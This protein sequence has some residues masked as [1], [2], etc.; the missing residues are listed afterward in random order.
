MLVL[1]RMAKFPGLIQEHPLRL[2]TL[3]EVIGFMYPKI[4]NA[5]STSLPS[6]YSAGA[7]DLEA[8][9]AKYSHTMVAA[10]RAVIS[11]TS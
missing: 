10:A 7:S 8:R 2:M 3:G 1:F 5:L 6:D 11:A 9:S 4:G